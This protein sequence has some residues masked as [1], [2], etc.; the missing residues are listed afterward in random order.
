[1]A[2]T[3]LLH[4]SDIENSHLTPSDSPEQIV[5]VHWFHFLF[6]LEELTFHLFDFCQS[7]FRKRP[8]GAE[9][10]AYRLVSEAIGDEEPLFFGFDESSSPEHMEVLGSICE[11]HAG[12]LSQDLD[13]PFT[14][15]EKVEKFQPLWTRN[16]FAD[17]GELLVDCVFEEAV[18]RFH[19]S[20]LN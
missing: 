18:W 4:W 8:H 15:T 13:R 2:C 1:V 9:K 17:S 12:F 6:L 20:I 7:L 14:L 11:A 3:I 19:Y 5:A 10:I 16:G